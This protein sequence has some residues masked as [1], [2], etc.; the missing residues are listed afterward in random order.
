MLT[1]LVE[2]NKIKCHEYYPKLNGMIKLVNITVRCVEEHKYDN[3]I[4]RILE[5]EK[6]CLMFCVCEFF[7]LD[8]RVRETKAFQ[9]KFG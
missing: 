1:S 8:L 3:Y 7:I 2:G 9:Q 6:V 4:K 5:V